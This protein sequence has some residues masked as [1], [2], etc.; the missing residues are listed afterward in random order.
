MKVALYTYSTKPR[1]GV[2]HTLALAEALA[3]QG[4]R[5]TVFALGH[6]GSAR[7]FR[8]VRAETRVFPFPPIA[9]EPIE[10]KIRRSI[11]T[12]AEALENEPLERFDVHHA[13]DCISANSLHRLKEKGKIP[14]FLRTVHHLDDFTTPV[15]IECQNRSVMHPKAIITVSD[16]WR[17]ILQREYGR[18]PV[19]I[20]NGVDKRFFAA[21]D[22]TADELAAYK[23]HRVLFTLGGIEPRKNTIASLQAFAE[24]KR[25][26]PEAVL[27]IGGGATLFD[28]RPYR[29]QFDATLERMPRDVRE[30]VRLIPQP[31]DE[32][33]HQLFWRADVYLQPSVK[34]GWGLS[35][36]EA[37]ASRTPVVASHIQVFR[38]FLRHEA[39]AL[40][41]DP[42]RIRDLADGI[43]R[44]LTDHQLRERLTANGYRTARAYTWDNAAVQHLH[45]YRSV[46]S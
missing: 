37:M 24:I 12:F 9:G 40:L 4:C 38:E 39:N 44:V 36:L 15:L 30:A 20:H 11:D 6:G 13:Q 3:D 16:Y 34:E 14:F 23:G 21:P 28:Y 43:Y 45:F 1:G 32:L 33:V 19:V 26:L 8:D 18:S 5:V 46:L 2:V 35:V 25:E 42:R 31:S 10:A 17:D 22:R 41:V 27:L 7:F 29:A